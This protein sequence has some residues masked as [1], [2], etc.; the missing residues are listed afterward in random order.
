[1][2]HRF[3]RVIL[4][5]R[6]IV[7]MVVAFFLPMQQGVDVFFRVAEGRCLTGNG[8]HLPEG[9]DDKKKK[10]KPTTHLQSLAERFGFDRFPHTPSE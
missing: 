8:D 4:H 1:M 7:K 6:T 3:V 2:L 5:H 10:D 9:G